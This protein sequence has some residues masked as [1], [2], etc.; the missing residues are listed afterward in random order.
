MLLYKGRAAIQCF[1]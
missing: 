1:L